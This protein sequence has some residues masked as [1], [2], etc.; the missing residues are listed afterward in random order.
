MAE[1]NDAFV[2]RGKIGRQVRRVR[3]DGWSA[4]RRQIFLDHYAESGNATEACR[5]AGMYEG[6]AYGL[7]RRDPD[8]ARQY[9]EALA[10]SKLRLEEMAIQYAKTGGRIVPVEPGEI[11]PVD[12]ANFDPELALKILSRSRPSQTPNSRV[13]AKPR[14]ASREELIEAALKL[15]AMLKRRRAK[16]AAA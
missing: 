15:L 11:A 16:R 8:F 7:R 4:R 13:G 14:Q 9:D 5:A 10:V 12:L 1:E 6:A 3:K 2:S